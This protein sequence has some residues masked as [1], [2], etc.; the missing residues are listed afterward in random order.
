MNVP[1]KFVYWI[2][3]VNY[4]EDL[5][6]KS[7]FI[8]ISSACPDIGIYDNVLR[9]LGSGSNYAY[10]ETNQ[11]DR[12]IKNLNNI[13]NYKEAYYLAANHISYL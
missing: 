12:L 2:D 5:I 1:P 10:I 4:Y 3:R 9:I 6:S 8:Y 7:T 13:S 11:R